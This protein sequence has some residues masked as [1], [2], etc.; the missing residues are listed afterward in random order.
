MDFLEAISAI[1]ATTGQL[2]AGGKASPALRKA[3]LVI[4]VSL[5]RSGNEIENDG[6]GNRSWGADYRLTSLD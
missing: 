1:L 4:D 2:G 5:P 3:Q 6:E